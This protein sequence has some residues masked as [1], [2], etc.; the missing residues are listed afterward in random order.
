VAVRR[1]V[2]GDRWR[3]GRGRRSCAPGPFR[4]RCVRFYWISE[5]WLE[6]KD[7]Q[8]WKL[9]LTSPVSLGVLISLRG[10]SAHWFFIFSSWRMD[11]NWRDQNIKSLGSERKERD[12]SGHLGLNITV[13]FISSI[14]RAKT[15]LRLGNTNSLRD[16]IAA[17]VLPHMK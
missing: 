12:E 1:R 3:S 9:K 2:L 5:S 6:R 11:S 16:M 14:G 4:W 13:S 10:A 15:A 8:L 7:E 17:A